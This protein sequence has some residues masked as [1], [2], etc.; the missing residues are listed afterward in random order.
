MTPSCY[1]LCGVF[2]DVASIYANLLQQ[3]NTKRVQLLKDWFGTSAWPPFHSFG[4]P[5]WLPFHCCGT[6]TWLPFHCFGTP[7]WLPF[8][9]CGTPTWPPFH[10]SGTLSWAPLHFFGTPIWICNVMWKALLC[11]TI[12]GSGKVY[13]CDII[14]KDLG[15]QKKGKKVIYFCNYRYRRTDWG[16]LGALQLPQNL[17]KSKEVSMFSFSKR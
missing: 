2:T 13:V 5:I 4:T 14:G 1:G 17:G 15:M 12:W 9:C 16:L 8:H 10:W 7:T 3:K 11:I 6:P